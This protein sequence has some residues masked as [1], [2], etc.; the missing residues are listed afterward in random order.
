MRGELGAIDWWFR[1][2]GRRI[3]KLCHFFL[4]ESA[5]GETT[6]QR[7]EGITEC[8]FLSADEAL[9]RLS[10]ANARNVLKRAVELLRGASQRLV[11]LEGRVWQLSVWYARA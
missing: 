4:F 1:F 3:H 11:P 9:S 5:G 8:E 2:R 10:Y 6:P 7:A